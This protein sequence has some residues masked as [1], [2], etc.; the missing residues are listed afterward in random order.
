MLTSRDVCSL[1]IDNSCRR[2]FE[3]YFF[4]SVD[5]RAVQNKTPSLSQVRFFSFKYQPGS[6]RVVELWYALSCCS[7]YD[8]TNC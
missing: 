3:V 5:V 2:R 7:M 6:W 8:S 1:V 4:L